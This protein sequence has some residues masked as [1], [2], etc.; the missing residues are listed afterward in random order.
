MPHFTTSGRD[1]YVI[2]C[3]GKFSA[4]AKGRMLEDYLRQYGLIAIFMAVAVAVPTGML[5]MSWMA[6]RIGLRP[7]N[8]SEVK[9]DTY[10]CGMEAIGGRWNQFNFRYY[11][12]AILFVVFDVEV[13]FMY[14]FAAT[15]QDFIAEGQGGGVLLVAL[16]FLGILAIGLL[17]EMKKGGAKWDWP[18]H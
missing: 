17:Y 8:P 2:I 6:S 9:E 15:F 13:V 14:P 12:Y 1:S 7:R 4:P 5:V 18:G 16:I 10:E 11:M 3:P